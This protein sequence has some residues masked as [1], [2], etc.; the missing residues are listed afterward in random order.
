M[1]LLGSATPD[2]RPPA[3]TVFLTAGPDD[4]MNGLSGALQYARRSEDS[5]N[6]T[7]LVISLR[8]RNRRRPAQRL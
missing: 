7:S 8:K 2:P 5:R 6:A 4:E 1:P 3:T